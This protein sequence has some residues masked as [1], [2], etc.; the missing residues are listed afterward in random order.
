MWRETLAPRWHL[1]VEIP[2]TCRDSVVHSTL[3]FPSA[4]GDSSPFSTASAYLDHIIPSSRVPSPRRRSP[5]F[6]PPHVCRAHP[7]EHRLNPE[8]DYLYSTGL[9]LQKQETPTHSNQS[10]TTTT[11]R[12]RLHLPCKLARRSCSIGPLI[13]HPQHFALAAALS[14]RPPS[15][16]ANYACTI[17]LHLLTP[18]STPPTS[19]SH[20]ISLSPSSASPRHPLLLTITS[21]V[22]LL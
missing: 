18:L 19:S 2:P 5:P 16:I 22:L 12:H 14:K 11:A 20:L 1:S 21:L 7:L 15:T 9:P 3:L 4:F 10:D 6:Y 8:P 17:P 13:V